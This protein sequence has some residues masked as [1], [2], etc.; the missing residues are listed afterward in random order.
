M[1][2][3]IHQTIFRKGENIPRFYPKNTFGSLVRVVRM[4]ITPEI[5]AG[6]RGEGGASPMS[7]VVDKYLFRILS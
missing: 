5:S 6:E 3:K 1:Y 2:Y 7:E 4:G